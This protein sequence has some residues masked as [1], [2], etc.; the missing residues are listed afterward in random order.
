M[1]TAPP[2]TC[3]CLSPGHPR[4]DAAPPG[5]SAGENSLARIWHGYLI[6]AALRLLVAADPTG[7]SRMLAGHRG[8]LLLPPRRFLRPRRWRRRCSAPLPHVAG[9]GSRI[10]LDLGFLV[11]GPG[12]E[13]G[14]T[15]V[16]GFTS[17]KKRTGSSG[18]CV[19]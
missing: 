3:T 17:L 15:V 18:C 14:K 16:G 10:G 8:V 9:P 5:A 12:F 4:S 2:I 19:R 13:P 7:Y 1:R 6:F 11:A